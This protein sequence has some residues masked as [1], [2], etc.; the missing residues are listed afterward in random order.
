MQWSKER[1]L[2]FLEVY[3]T[4]PCIWDPRHHEHKNR[5]TVAV[6]W[7]N[8]HDILNYN[9]TVN[10]LKKKRDSLMASFRMLLNKKKKCMNSNSEELFEPHW[11]AYETMA[12]F[13]GP[14]YFCR[15]ENTSVEETDTYDEEVACF[16][17]EDLSNDDTF[18][19]ENNEEINDKTS[20]QLFSFPSNRLRD[21]NEA[22][23]YTE[24]T[25]HIPKAV[26]KL[27]KRKCANEEIDDCDLYGQLLAR[28]LRKFS[29]HQREEIMFEIDGL[30]IQKRKAAMLR[31]LNMSKLSS[32]E[33]SHSPR[34]TT[35]SS[36]Y[37]SMEGAT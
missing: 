3:R 21:I 6:A 36:E 24:E 4:Q 27:P 13:L 33:V 7:Q 29:E 37:S 17:I 32:A 9:C 11:F 28:K 25:Y 14:I 8:I 2:K 22:E 23:E 12:K 26:P 16:K 31:T 34:S 35:T 1:V 30:V 18:N 15:T 5:S 19:Y 10:E 20:S